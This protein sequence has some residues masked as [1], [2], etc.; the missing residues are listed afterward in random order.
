MVSC[1]PGTWSSRTR[2]YSRSGVFPLSSHHPAHG[3]DPMGESPAGKLAAPLKQEPSG[4]LWSKGPPAWAGWQRASLSPWSGD[5][6][7]TSSPRGGGTGHYP[8]PASSPFLLPS[9]GWSLERQRLEKPPCPTSKEE[10]SPQ[11]MTND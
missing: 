9:P 6:G 7:A 8:T 4:Q 1:L 10:T 5:A 3:W 2:G 11:W